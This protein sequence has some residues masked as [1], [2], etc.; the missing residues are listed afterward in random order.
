MSSL[1][2]DIDAIETQAGLPTRKASFSSSSK[3]EEQDDS[4]PQ[5]QQQQSP[6]T[7]MT[8]DSPRRS[9]SMDSSGRSSNSTSSGSNGTGRQATGPERSSISSTLVSSSTSFTAES[10][11][12]TAFCTAEL[13]SLAVMGDTLQGIA[14]KAR[15]WTRTSTLMCEAAGRLSQCCKLQQPT[16]NME[17][18]LEGKTPRQV[19]QLQESIHQHRR[20]AVGEDMASLLVHVGSVRNQCLE[21]NQSQ[22]SSNRRIWSDIQNFRQILAH[23]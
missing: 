15:T 12:Y 9:I 4:Q 18:I 6:S 19:Q 10:P 14:E 23:L 17:A 3:N 21:I 22:Q 13:Q 7:E 20:L 11:Y 2:D 1:S 5:Q 8:K 16:P